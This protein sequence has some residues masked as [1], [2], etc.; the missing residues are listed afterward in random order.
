[1]RIVTDV[2]APPTGQ[3]TAPAPTTAHSTTHS[4]TPPAKLPITGP[5]DVATGALAIGLPTLILG[6]VILMVLRRRRARTD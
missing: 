6:A 3:P 5:S 2:Q 4:T 1:M